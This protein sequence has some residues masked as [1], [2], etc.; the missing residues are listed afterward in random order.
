MAFEEYKI[1]KNAGKGLDPACISVSVVGK[2]NKNLCIV[3]GREFMAE[4]GLAIGD[5][6]AMYFGTGEDK[7]KLLLVKNQNGI[8]IAIYS[9]KSKAE[10]AHGQLLRVLKPI[11]PIEDFAGNNIERT[12]VDFEVDKDSGGVLV[13]LP[14]GFFAA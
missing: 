6:L 3:L 5:K 9:K 10:D 11:K 4:R 14:D 1:G 12:V 7:G 8:A 13:T 2:K